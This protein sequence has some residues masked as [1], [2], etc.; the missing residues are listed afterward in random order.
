MADEDEFEDHCL[1]AIA[2]AIQGA[3]REFGGE[4]GAALLRNDVSD[5]LAAAVL[6]SL[7]KHRLEI[8]EATNA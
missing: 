8:A 7:R 4:V 1:R 6:A 2:G 3:S 5:R